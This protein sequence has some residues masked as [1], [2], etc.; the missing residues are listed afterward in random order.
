M[1][2]PYTTDPAE[3]QGKARRL[4]TDPMTLSLAHYRVGCGYAARAVCTNQDG[5]A[6]MVVRLSDGVAWMA[7]GKDPMTYGTIAVGTTCEEVFFQDPW[8]RVG[9]VRLD[10]LGPGIPPD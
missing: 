9:R 10:S 1:T 8:G 4:R 6:L 2:A 7:R 5:C 3:A